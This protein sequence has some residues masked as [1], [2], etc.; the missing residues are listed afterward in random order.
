MPGWMAALARLNPLTY[1][2][3]GGRSLMVGSGAGGPFP[4]PYPEAVL[5][6]LAF[7]AVTVYLAYKRAKRHVA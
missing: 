6:L 4:A 5:A 1:A 7:N 2:V 3:D